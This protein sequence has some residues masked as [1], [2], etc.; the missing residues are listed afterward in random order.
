MPDNKYCYPNSNILRNKLQIQDKDKL[1]QAEI[2]M[3]GNRMIELQNN[4]VS[5]KF[6]FQHLCDIHKRIFQDL[7]DWAGE[8]RTV[9]IGKN[10][11]F[12]LVQHIPSYAASIFNNYYKDCMGAKNDRQNF[13]HVLAE[14]YADLNALHPFREGNGRSQREF[15][16]ELCLKCGYMFDLS[17]TNHQEML[18]A[19][20][21][22]FNTG[23]NKK[24]EN[25]FQKAIAPIEDY[26]SL[27]MKN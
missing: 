8:T 17:T 2:H 20:I 19:S 14:H 6:D 3:T 25:I 10:N 5:G 11:L 16:R 13:V 7:Y 18:D 24:L 1:L 23:N 26:E 9:N 27:P 22:S 15:T 12:C 4:P 21:E